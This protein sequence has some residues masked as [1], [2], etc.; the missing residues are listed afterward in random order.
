MQLLF[1]YCLQ[2][3][4][5]IATDGMGIMQWKHRERKYYTLSIT[6]SAFAEYWQEFSLAVMIAHSMCLKGP[7][8][9]S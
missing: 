8:T 9:W 4:W 1:R 7:Q 3:N 5:K 2:E 6:W